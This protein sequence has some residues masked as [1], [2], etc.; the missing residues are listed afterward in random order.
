MISTLTI[1]RERPSAELISISVDVFTEHWTTGAMSM[2]NVWMRKTVKL[3]G[4]WGEV[5]KRYPQ[6]HALVNNAGVGFGPRGGVRQVSADGI[7]LRF[8]VNHLAG[9]LLARRLTDR[10]VSFAPARIV[11]VTSISQQAL[12]LADL[13]IERHYKRRDRIPALSLRRSFRGVR[14]AT[15]PPEP[16]RNRA[17]P[18]PY[19]PPTG[20]T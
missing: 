20:G 6:L 1:T 8:A 9:Y 2:L 12:D 7:E 11:Q 16:P 5:L 19:I 17:G 18:S 10:L 15:G 13:F 3:S 4:V 14:A